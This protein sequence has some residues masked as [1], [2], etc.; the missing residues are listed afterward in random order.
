MQIL[1][2]V[3][4]LFFVAGRLGAA[5]L[6]SDE[7][8]GKVVDA[9]GT[10]SLKSAEQQRWTPVCGRLV[11][12]PGDWLR[13]DLR[14]ANAAEV[15][16]QD[17][18]HLI[19]GPGSQVE[20][21]KPSE[22]R[23]HSGEFEATPAPRHA[24]RIAGPQKQI[25]VVETGTILRVDGDKLVTLK[26]Q[27]KWL[28]GF[29]GTIAGEA[30]GSLVAK[31]DGH[32]VPL[33]VGYHKATVDI[34]DQIARTVIEESFVNHTGGQLEG[35][36]YFPLPADA[37]ISGFGMWIGNELVEADVVEKQRAREIYESFLRE[38]HDPGL[39]EWS[40]G[41]L[42]KARVFPIPGGAEKRIKI[43]Y[44]QV[45][46]LRGRTYRYSYA[47][48]SE[49]LKQH[50]LAELS[51]D[52]KISST[53]PLADVSCGTHACRVSHTAHAGHVEFS[54]Q[55]YA[56]D[57]DFEV[58]VELEPGRPDV[59]LVPHQRA[60]DG[61]F[62]LTISPPGA[63]TGW[64]REL[65]ADGKPLRLLILADTSGSMDAGL[66]K[67]QDAF[68]AALLG[69]LGPR[70]SFNL[71]ACDVHCD[72]AFPD[73]R[74]AGEKSVARARSFLARRRSL[75]WTNLGEAFAAVLKRTR[76]GTHVIYIGD[77]IVTAPDA[78]PV[79][80]VNRLKR[81]T[82]GR[83]GTFHAVACG[84]KFELPV[85]KAI[86]AVGDGSLRKIQSGAAASSETG[87]QATARQLLSELTQPGFCAI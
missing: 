22:F 1:R 76:P 50:P 16:L 20:L 29:K 65:L 86:A 17:G 52:V 66:R 2:A 7:H 39:L 78:D 36:F 35:T 59:A 70:D 33:S 44:T 37:S 21:I 56:P 8:L 49:L 54:A 74:P 4:V 87:P 57:R 9:Q 84:S 60:E 41:N 53:L 75:G 19:L 15:R 34:R 73:D 51:L 79:A 13:T 12:M 43:S 68:L 45:L 69:S 38:R 77:G 42:F 64:Q 24:L 83:P 72:W 11:L 58:A 30:L 5:T 25:V 85:L 10:V 46:P 63:D 32:N 48:E 26:Q 6:A 18:G 31:I 14:G 3:V 55:E 40:G 61:Y 28:Q 23:V 47:L 71:A 62:L 80:F 82:D 67:T 27:P 81:L